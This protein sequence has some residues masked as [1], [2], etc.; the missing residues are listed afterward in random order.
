[1][2]VITI[3][4]FATEKP[5]SNIKNQEEQKTLIELRKTISE[6]NKT[7]QGIP[8]KNPSKKNK[9][10]S[11]IANYSEREI[12][13][14]LEKYKP[15]KPDVTKFDANTIEKKWLTQYHFGCLLFSLLNGNFYDAKL[16]TFFD[17]NLDFTHPIGTDQS[18]KQTI[19]GVVHEYKAILLWLLLTH[20]NVLHGNLRIVRN[21]VHQMFS[22]KSAKKRNELSKKIRGYIL[23]KEERFG[24][25]YENG[26]RL[27]FELS[28]W[29]INGK[30]AKVLDETHNKKLNDIKLCYLESLPKYSLFCIGDHWLTFLGCKDKKMV[31]WDSKK[32]KDFRI[33]GKN[34][35]AEKTRAILINQ[36]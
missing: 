4:N 32:H 5:D 7:L 18:E 11:I 12:E 30:K 9:G 15:V 21:L 19:I 3:E 29:S 23:N 14:W 28:E 6:L 20:N 1:M 34:F 17:F 25:K 16:K 22:N 2:K 35:V 33:M 24:V 10:H 8:D 13:N 27:E 36:P 26:K 31:F